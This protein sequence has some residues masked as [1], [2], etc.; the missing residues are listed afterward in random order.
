MQSPSEKSSGKVET[1][2]TERIRGP[3]SRMFHVEH[4]TPIFFRNYSLLQIVEC[5]TWNIPSRHPWISGS[6][7]WRLNRRGNRFG[8]SATSCMAR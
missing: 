7:I 5:S 2:Q 6:E 3:G 4:V 1:P 8:Q